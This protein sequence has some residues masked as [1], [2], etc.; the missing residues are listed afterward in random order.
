LTLFRKE[1]WMEHEFKET[2]HK[3]DNIDREVRKLIQKFEEEERVRRAVIEM[4]V[5]MGNDA[6]FEDDV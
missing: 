4:L 1:A 2:G 5:M 6:A 3:E